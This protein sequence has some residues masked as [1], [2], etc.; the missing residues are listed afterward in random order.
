M[1]DA[2]LELGGL[3]KQYSV[4]FKQF[5]TTAHSCL[6]V[7][8]MLQHIHHGDH[9]K[10]C[11]LQVL[12]LDRTDKNWNVKGLTTEF[13]HPWAHLKSRCTVTGLLQ[14]GHEAAVGTSQLQHICC[15]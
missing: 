8:E 9:V 14:Q 10:A 3:D 5:Q 1:T 4:R 7:R 2:S 12:C 13:S 6:R 11:W 15:R